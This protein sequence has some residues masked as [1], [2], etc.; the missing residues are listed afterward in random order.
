MGTVPPLTFIQWSMSY[1]HTEVVYRRSGEHA[2]LTGEDSGYD[3]NFP[4]CTTCQMHWAFLAYYC[5]C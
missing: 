4:P 5:C 2:E 1:M 3:F